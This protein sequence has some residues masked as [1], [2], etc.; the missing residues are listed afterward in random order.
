M[1]DK[2]ENKSMNKKEKVK[3]KG[4]NLICIKRCE[5]PNLGYWKPGDRVE[6]GKTAELLKNNKRFFKSEEEK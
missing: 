4:L 5:V 3:T 1:I 6:D 2:Q